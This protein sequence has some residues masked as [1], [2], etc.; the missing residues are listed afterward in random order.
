M[1]TALQRR[2]RLP[3]RDGAAIAGTW[4]DPDDDAEI[5][6][7]A[8]VAPAMATPAGFYTGFAECLADDGIAALAFDYRGYGAS[9]EGSLRDVVAD[10]VQWARDAADAMLAARARADALGVPLTWI[11][12]SLGGQVLPW[13]EHE[14]LDAAILVA[15]GSGYRAHLPPALRRRARFGW[16]LARPL[17]AIFGYF[18]GRRVRFFG[19]LPS[20]PLLQWARWCSHPEYYLGEFP[21]LRERLA[22][23]RVPVSLLW[24]S[25]DELLAPSSFAW[26][27]RQF[28]RADVS[29][30]RIDPAEEGRARV[31]HHGIFRRDAR[32]LWDRYVI[33]R[34]PVRA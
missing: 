14:R 17:T 11:G 15:A 32:A 25:D 29:L 6:G 34:I 18:P 27:A 8:L 22:A 1:T 4:F 10:A 3:M 19:D 28:T 21:Q 5:R 9:L 23:V 7:V 12:H 33:P 24:A 30:V 20:G 26:L 16:R 2:V 31:G 13:A